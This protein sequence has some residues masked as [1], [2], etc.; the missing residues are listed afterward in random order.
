MLELA[1]HCIERLVLF[2][3]FMLCMFWL[4]ERCF[5]SSDCHR[6]VTLAYSVSLVK[7][8]LKLNFFSF[9][10]KS[11]WYFHS[12]SCLSLF[13]SRKMLLG[14]RQSHPSH[15]GVTLATG[16]CGRGHLALA[17][18]TIIKRVYLFIF[19]IVRRAKAKWPRPQGPVLWANMNFLLKSTP[20]NCPAPWPHL[21]NVLPV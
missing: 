1:K 2:I 15:A 12:I 19:I 7:Q 6:P 21:K 20:E 18:L 16:P 5:S 4:F 13:T 8:L 11:G 14:Q 10:K 17:L 9:R 3:V